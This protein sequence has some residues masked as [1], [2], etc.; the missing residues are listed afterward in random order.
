MASRHWRSQRCATRTVTSTKFTSFRLIAFGPLATPLTARTGY[1][2][3]TL[4]FTNAGSEVRSIS[5]NDG[6]S[7]DRFVIVVGHVSLHRGARAE[8]SEPRVIDRGSGFAR[9]DSAHAARASMRIFL[10]FSRCCLSVVGV[11]IQTDL[12]CKKRV[13]RPLRGKQ[14]II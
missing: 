6:V 10:W 3:L 11:R 9:A 5:R 7:P 12:K 1:R 8:H 2:V 13:K 14:E 4:M